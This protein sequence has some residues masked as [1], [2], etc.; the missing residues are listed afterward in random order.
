VADVVTGASV[1]FII[2]VAV[3]VIDDVIASAAEA[4]LVAG[5]T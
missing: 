4:I 2:I 3:A 1:D 5:D